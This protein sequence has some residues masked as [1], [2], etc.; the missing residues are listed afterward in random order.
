[1]KLSRR[2]FLLS[3]LAL[4]YKPSWGALS[5]PLPQGHFVPAKMPMHPVFPRPDSE[6][7]AHARH[8]WAH[9]DFRYEIPIG[10][11]G[12]A[13]P[14]KYEILAG[15]SGATIGQY[16]GDP[17]YGVL[18]WTP[19]NGDSGIKFFRVRVTDQELNMVDLTWTTTIDAEQF[20][21]VD[22]AADTTGTGTISSPLKTF[23]DWYRGDRTDATYHN[24]IIVFRAG[25]YTAYGAAT[26][27]GNVRLDRSSKTPSLIGY[28]DEMPVID[29]GRAKFFTDEGLDD[30]FIA[31]LEFTNARTDVANP[32][33]FWAV[34]SWNR[35][36]WYAVTF[37]NMGMGTVN[38]DNPA[39]IFASH[40]SSLRE[41]LLFKNITFDRIIANGGNGAYI[42]LYVS[43]R[44]LIE[45]CKALNSDTSWGLWM[46]ATGSDVTIRDNKF[47][48]N[49]NNQVINFGHSNSNDGV[50]PIN[51][52]VCWNKFVGNTD[53]QELVQMVNKKDYQGLYYNTFIYRNTFAN[54][55][56]TLRFAGKEPFNVDGNV[57]VGDNRINWNDSTLIVSTIPNIV[58][59]TTSG[60]VDNNGL[61]SGI[62]R[63]NYL[64]ICGH[65]IS[66]KYV[67]TPKNPSHVLI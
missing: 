25:T 62:Y 10:V 29:C 37:S 42:D 13:W 66:D 58:Q 32:H 9:P 67:K 7:Q 35:G 51:Y 43:S 12:G 50:L 5:F 60:V 47:D 6:T 57:V 22:A 34:K 65:E 17:D 18:K 63:K 46:K 30:I 40:S 16:Y 4:A 44:I 52:E 11:Q 39:C 54:G 20:V 24:K 23:T 15:P 33:F 55:R 28:P 53:S 27:S 2:L 49:I 14:F 31:A 26:T 41:N 45:G 36:T 21:F 3:P 61:L 64:G 59:P 1:M 19:S 48:T 8:R 38:N 56:I